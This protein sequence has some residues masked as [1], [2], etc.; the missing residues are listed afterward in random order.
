MSLVDRTVI[1]FI[2]LPKFIII[3]QVCCKINVGY[4]TNVCMAVVWNGKWFCECSG[5]YM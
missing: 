1:I 5:A 2:S 4:F 3:S